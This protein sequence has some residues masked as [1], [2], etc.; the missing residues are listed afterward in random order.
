M[1][2]KHK[3]VYTAEVENGAVEMKCDCGVKLSITVIDYEL[4][5]EGD[6]VT[7]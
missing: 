5:G 3:H 7:E 1:K 4:I 2:T 6:D